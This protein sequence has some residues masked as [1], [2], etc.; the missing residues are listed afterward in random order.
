[1][2]ILEWPMAFLKASFQIVFAIVLCIP[3]SYAWNAVAPEYFTFLPEEYMHI[4]YLHMV[5]ITLA[6]AWV[7]SLIGKLTPKVIDITQNANP[8]IKQQEGE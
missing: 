1:M 6:I 3:Y 8:Q 4:P 2:F 5:G 7:G